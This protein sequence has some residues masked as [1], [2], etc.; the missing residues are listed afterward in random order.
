MIA[1]CL[2]CGEIL[3]NNK[4][5]SRKTCSCPNEAFIEGDK[6]GCKTPK[7]IHD[8]ITAAEA[9]RMSHLVTIR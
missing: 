3:N 2:C 8:A 5:K 1:V 4:D 6:M 7:K 9:R